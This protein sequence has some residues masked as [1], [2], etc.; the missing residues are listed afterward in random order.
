MNFPSIGSHLISE[1]KKE[2]D[3]FTTL[4]DDRD[5][6]QRASCNSPPSKRA[7]AGASLWAVTRH[8]CKDPCVRVFHS[9]NPTTKCLSISFVPLKKLPTCS[10][11]PWEALHCAVRWAWQAAHTNNI[12]P[13]QL[14]KR[15][16]Q[17]VHRRNWITLH[18]RLLL[19]C[20]I[21]TT[22]MLDERAH[23]TSSLYSGPASESQSEKK[24]HKTDSSS[25]L[26]ASHIFIP[27]LIAALH[28]R[29]ED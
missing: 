1:K 15:Q 12:Q 23:L 29:M 4:T 5:R 17:W 20:L 18:L 27:M 25:S 28:A 21:G 16:K 9:R 6:W 3:F 22:A 11:Q 2:D 7:R 8:M 10:L 26:I 24:S 19:L 14:L 13:C